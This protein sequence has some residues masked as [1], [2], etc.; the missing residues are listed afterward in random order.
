MVV[1]VVV[2]LLGFFFSFSGIFS[3]ILFFGD[4]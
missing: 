3:R 2:Y 4:T 1:R